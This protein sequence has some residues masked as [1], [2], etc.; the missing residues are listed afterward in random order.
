MIGSEELLECDEETDSDTDDEDADKVVNGG[1]S[2]EP[3]RE[4]EPITGD[5][6]PVG[7]VVVE[8]VGVSVERQ[9]ED[10]RK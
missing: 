6:S 1:G 9:W 5:A 3:D 4:A 2:G 10:K 7:V 8:D